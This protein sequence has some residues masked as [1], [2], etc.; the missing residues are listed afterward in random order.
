MI[1]IAAYFHSSGK[2]QARMKA[3]SVA[4]N[5]AAKVMNELLDEKPFD[6][7][8]G[9]LT[10]VADPPIEGVE[11]EWSAEVADT[12]PAAVSFDWT[13]TGAGS[14]DPHPL[15][16]NILDAK[17]SG[18]PCIKDIKLTIQWKSPRDNSMGGPSRTQILITRRARL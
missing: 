4:A 3:E 2:Q 17:F 11:I 6:E 12:M 16:A 15:K 8:T 18:K 1:P 13:P 9:T 7:V 5:Y 10:G 14:A